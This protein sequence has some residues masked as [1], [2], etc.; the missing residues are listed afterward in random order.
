MCMLNYPLS[1]V[2]ESEKGDLSRLDPGCLTNA[3]SLYHCQ[4]ATEMPRVVAFLPFTTSFRT[5]PPAQPPETIDM[6]TTAPCASAIPFVFDTDLDDE[7]ENLRDEAGL[8]HWKMWVCNRISSSL[9][10]DVY[11]L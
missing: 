2:R 1:R 6:R 11:S 4:Y 10:I 3:C 7:D 5:S 8:G 9:L